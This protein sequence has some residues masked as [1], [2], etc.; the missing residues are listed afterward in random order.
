MQTASRQQ[1]HIEQEHT[2]MQGVNTS[3]LIRCPY[4]DTVILM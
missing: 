2:L 4:P 3:P 1:K